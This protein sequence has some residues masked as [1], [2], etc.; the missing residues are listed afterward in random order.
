M[1][2]DVE[3]GHDSVVST[4][5]NRLLRLAQ[6]CEGFVVAACDPHHRIYSMRLDSLGAA[7]VT[8]DDFDD[9]PVDC[10]DKKALLI[11][12]QGHNHAAQNFEGHLI[13]I[14]NLLGLVEILIPDVDFS[15]GRSEGDALEALAHASNFDFVVV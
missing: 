1:G 5:H 11:V 6:N 10:C 4:H 3:A 7:S 14:H 9:V 13:D 2:L 8:Q 12:V 15:V